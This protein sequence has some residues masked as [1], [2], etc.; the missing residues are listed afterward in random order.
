MTNLW[1][2]EPLLVRMLLR[3]STSAAMVRTTTAP[4]ILNAGVQDNVLP[5]RATAVVNHRILPGDTRESVTARVAEVIDDD[6]VQLR[7]VSA[8]Y[9]PSP[10]SS[11][12]A[13][14]FAALETDL[15]GPSCGSTSCHGGGSGGLIPCGA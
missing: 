15:L 1:L 14:G 6:R 12:E 8:S 9:D 3:E 10:I 7:D 5:I 2:F 4:T 13:P 11:T